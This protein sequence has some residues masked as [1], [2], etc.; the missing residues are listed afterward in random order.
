MNRKSL[1]PK[2]IVLAV[3]TVMAAVFALG[4]KH[5]STPIDTTPSVTPGVPAKA[6][7]TVAPTATPLPTPTPIIDMPLDRVTAEELNRSAEEEGELV[8]SGPAEWNVL[9]PFYST[10]P[11][12]T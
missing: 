2:W 8:I 10:E 12:E 1:N 5:T 4:C 6:T 9:N 7:P 3:I 11:Q